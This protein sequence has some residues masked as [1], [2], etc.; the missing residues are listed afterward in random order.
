MDYTQGGILNSA[1]LFAQKLELAVYNVT[2]T[3]PGT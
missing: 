2:C 1:R 3:E